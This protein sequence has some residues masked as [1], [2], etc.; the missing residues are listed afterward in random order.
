MIQRFS[1]KVKLVI[2]TCWSSIYVK[3]VSIRVA[4]VGCKNSCDIIYSCHK[5]RMLPEPEKIEHPNISVVSV[6]S[7]GTE[8]S[9]K[10][11]NTTKR[12]DVKAIIALSGQR[13]AG[14]EAP[15]KNCRSLHKRSGRRGRQIPS[16]THTA[17]LRSSALPY[18]SFK[19]SR[20]GNSGSRAV[21]SPR[22]TPPLQSTEQQTLPTRHN[23]GTIVLPYTMGVRPADRYD[24]RWITSPRS[25]STCEAAT[26][27]QGTPC[28]KAGGVRIVRRR[29]TQLPANTH[30]PFHHWLGDQFT[31][32]DPRTRIC[33]RRRRE[34]GRYF[35]RIILFERAISPA[36]SLYT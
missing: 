10:L 31:N 29:S 35:S 28:N 4:R 17:L 11:V 18:V 1:P 20:F 36:F 34:Q 21:P 2:G 13:R 8:R 5:R 23:L 3:Q 16:S 33:S 14:Q 24:L 9:A 27:R 6:S 30:S 15:D 32:L 7:N 26:P 12:I 22:A 19:W 25:A